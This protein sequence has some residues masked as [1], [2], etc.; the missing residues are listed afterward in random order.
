MAPLQTYSL[1]L[2]LVTLYGVVYEGA[3]GLL[4]CS[5]LRDAVNCIIIIIIIISH[6]G[7]HL[8]TI[9]KLKQKTTNAE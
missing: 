1:R 3:V 5:D 8:K 9:N 6:Q 7:V 2:S 4:F